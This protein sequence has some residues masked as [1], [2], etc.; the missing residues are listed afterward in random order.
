MNRLQAGISALGGTDMTQFFL[1][2][3]PDMKEVFRRNADATLYDFVD[4]DKMVVI[5]RR[6]LI[7]YDVLIQPD[8]LKILRILDPSLTLTSRV[9]LTKAKAGLFADEARAEIA[10]RKELLR[11]AETGE[12][13]EAIK[14][15]ATRIYWGTYSLFQVSRK[16]GING[17]E[18]YY[19]AVRK[20]I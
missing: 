1:G 19:L 11:T 8:I 3:F 6:G 18:P 7:S 4:P 9:D 16:A 10:K 15:L 2:A 14:H 12:H 17:Y 13:A 20:S 5:N